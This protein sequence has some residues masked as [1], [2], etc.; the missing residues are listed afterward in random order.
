M[1][2]GST[3]T[4]RFLES[5][6]R[7]LTRRYRW[8]IAVSLLLAVVGGYYSVHLYKN[9]RTDMEE[10]LPENAESVKDLKSVGTRVGGLNHISI[11]MESSD[12]EAGVRLMK[13][14]AAKL[15][16]LPPTLVAR[17]E[18]NINSAKAFFEK[19]KSLY[20]DLSDWEQVL[21]YVKDRMR[22][23]RSAKKNPFSL[24]L[25]DEDASK[26]TYDFE[27][28]KKKY[29]ERGNQVNRFREGYFES[30]DGRTHVVLGFLPG[31]T[32][33]MSSNK[34]LSEEAHRIVNELNPK[35][36]APDMVVG[37]NGDVQNM[38][39]EHEGLIEDLVTSSILVLLVVGFSMLL[40]FRSFFGVYALCA[41]LGA[42]TLVT[43]GV[44]Y[45]LVGYLNANTAFLGSIVIGNGINFGI[46]FL[47]RYLE[48]RRSGLQWE[49]AMP[50]AIEFT[51]QATWT[52]A[53]AAGIAY[54][55]LML[56]DFRGFNQFGV[57]GGVGMML[58]WLACFLTMPALLIALEKRG[59][60]NAKPL[61]N[62]NRMFAI[63]ARVVTRFHKPIC[64]AVAISLVATV[65]YIAKLN[66]SVIETDFSKLRNKQALLTGSGYWGKK[67][68]AVF[69]RYLTPTLVMTASPDDA[70]IVVESI[71]KVKAQ[72][73]ASTAIA[74]INVVDDFVPKDQA[75]K[76]RVIADLKK[77]LS[78][79]VLERL[80][81]EDK[82]LAEELLP[83]G[84][85]AP[86]R[87]EDL[88]SALLVHFKEMNGTVG[89]MIHVYPKIQD[90]GFWD[91]RQ[92]I[93]FAETIR[94]GV[95]HSGAGAFIAGQPAL[96]ADLIQSISKDG[97]K[98]TLFALLAV[99]GLVLVLFPK[100]KYFRS[101]LGA[102]L[103][104]VGWMV[105]VISA[106]DLKINFLNFIALPITF[107]IGVDYA[108]NIFSRYRSDGNKSIAT[109]IQNTGGAVMLCSWSTIIGYGSLLIAGSQAFVSFGLLAVLGEVTCLLAALVALPAAWQFFSR[110]K[111]PEFFGVIKPSSSS[112]AQNV[113]KE[114]Q[115]NPSQTNSDE[116][117]P[118]M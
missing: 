52:A 9:L 27:A 98:A 115:F 87:Q 50:R 96:S 111:P 22:Y 31:R 47:A 114:S 107:G 46:I 102:L 51:A 76:M 112:S 43:F 93:R 97:P 62:E 79:K 12:R 17:V 83:A 86:I 36:Y 105:A 108:V 60:V 109:T 29:E 54:G 103:L 101:V 42:G 64:A 117:H 41:A 100:W 94:Q 99:M 10:L 91:G 106:L 63:L 81:K 90:A 80:S 84:E 25:E 2:S 73:G 66:Q 8:V 92:V 24:G 71:R 44:C 18:Y 3:T 14:V 34:R 68:D 82:K 69:E 19:N 28:L 57:I 23:E 13:D 67:V 78:P 59:L 11:V 77:L 6:S 116:L 70:R 74:D 56:T 7:W 85:L 55:S 37:Y 104:G 40:Y 118:P 58:C 20:M 21:K 53:L 35:S 32:T 61:R 72:Q 39:E 15:E 5:Y 65:V 45:F 113:R 89:N 38:V 49:A 88:P 33:D 4:I 30:R 48:E 1:H 75:K 95:R 26:P 110:E 16:A